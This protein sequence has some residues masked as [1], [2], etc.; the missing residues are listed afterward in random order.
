MKQLLANHSIARR[1]QLGVGVA[2]GLVLGLTVW[3]NS[4]V[5]RDELERQ[6]NAKAVTEIRAAARRLD[7]FITRIGMLPR[8]VAVRQQ[9]FGREPDPGMVSYMRELL[10]Q[11]PVEEVYG[12]YIAYEE[13]D[14]KDPG[15]C[16]AVHRKNWPAL[17]P[18]EYDYHDAQAE[19]AQALKQ[20]PAR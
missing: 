18:V 16:L 3:F 9:A 4:R 5:S 17:T 11:T 14:W 1:L 6:T 8:A 2:A 12:L 20:L 10:R 13:K 19:L 7:D 15:A